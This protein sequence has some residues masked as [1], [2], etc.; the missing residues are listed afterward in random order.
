M[1]TLELLQ[2]IKRRHDYYNRWLTVLLGGLVS[3]AFFALWW[4]DVALIDEYKSLTG[5][6]MMFLAFVFYKL[7]Y[8][9]YRFNRRYYRQNEDGLNMMGKSW[10]QYRN[11]I[12]LRY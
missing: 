12:I 4:N 2:Q 1:E 8:F 6:V 5:L 9:A 11:R 3:F 10:R 7:P